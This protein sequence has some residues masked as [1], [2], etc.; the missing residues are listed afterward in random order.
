MSVIPALGRHCE[1]KARKGY[2][3]NLKPAWTTY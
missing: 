1:F 2:I 3:E